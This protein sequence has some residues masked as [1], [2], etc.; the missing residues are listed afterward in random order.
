MMAYFILLNF[1]IPLFNLSVIHRVTLCPS[2]GVRMH[3]Y[4]HMYVGPTLSFNVVNTMDLDFIRDDSF[5]TF[6]AGIYV[7]SMLFISN[8][9][10]EL[11]WER[12][13]SKFN[14]TYSN[15]NRKISIDNRASFFKA[16]IGYQF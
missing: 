4:F 11:R 6:V 12:D 15:M 16:S 7:G 8:F 13:L 1:K 3:R 10:F 5:D 14:T 9:I 2:L